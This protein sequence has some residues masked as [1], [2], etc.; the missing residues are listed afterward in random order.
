MPNRVPEKTE[1]QISNFIKEYPTYGPERTE[2]EL[3]S[4][5]ISV[6]H[7]SIYNILKKRGLNTA[8]ARLEWVRKLSLRNSHP[9]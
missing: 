1:E 4:A 5:G 2:A 3:K 7:T 9:R 8:K 6:G